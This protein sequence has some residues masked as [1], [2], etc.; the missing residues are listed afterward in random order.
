MEQSISIKN[1]AEVM[2]CSAEQVRRMV[3]DGSLR[4]WR[5]KRGI[6]I[7]NSSIANY[8]NQNMIIPKE[9]KAKKKDK[10]GSSS[11]IGQLSR[12]LSSM[13]LL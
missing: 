9:E 2:G 11:K 13:G 7:F 5:F 12:E 3:E 4:G 10:R 6:R 8:Q 1:A